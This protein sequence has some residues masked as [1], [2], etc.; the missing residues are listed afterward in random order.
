MRYGRSRSSKVVDFGGNRKGLWNFLLVINCN[1]GPLSYR[2]LDTTTYWLKI[3]NFHLVPT[4]LS[5]C[6]L[7]RGDPIRIS[8]KASKFGKPDSTVFRGADSE[9]FVILACLILT[10]SQ[11][12][13]DRRTPLQ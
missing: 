5:F 2:F 12:V 4:P 6:A 1:L 13:T 11:S 9:D 7:D 10:Q 3:V 8:G